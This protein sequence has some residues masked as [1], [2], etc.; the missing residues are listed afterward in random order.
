M[1]SRRQ[2][3]RPTLQT[4]RV[5]R[6]GVQ[7]LL[8]VRTSGAAAGRIGLR[9]KRAEV[10]GSAVHSW[11]PLGRLARELG[12]SRPQLLAA[13][14]ADGRAN[15]DGS[16]TRSALEWGFARPTKLR[17]V[18]ASHGI[19]TWHVRRCMRILGCVR[20]AGREWELLV[21]AEEVD[22][23]LDECVRL[24][25]SGDTESLYRMLGTLDETVAAEIR[26]RLRVRPAAVLRF[27]RA[28]AR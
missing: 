7:Y 3:N 10:W 13:L 8:L 26:T 19:A 18:G 24:E 6:P 28:A 14:V 22:D 11:M 9:A 27:P 23:V 25:D 16:P 2:S 21:W 4:D 5:A 12:R 1:T 15:P 17:D 20:P